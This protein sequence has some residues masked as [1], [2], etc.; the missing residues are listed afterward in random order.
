M[1]TLHN[2][3]ISKKTSVTIKPTR[4]CYTTD[5]NI[6]KITPINFHQH[7]LRSHFC[8][9]QKCTRNMNYNN[10]PNRKLLANKL[11]QTL[12]APRHPKRREQYAK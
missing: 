11:T 9:P 4:N 7:F 6:N 2:Y 12:N 8:E 1:I 5:I 10:C 3:N